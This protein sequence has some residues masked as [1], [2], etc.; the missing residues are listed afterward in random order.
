MNLQDFDAL[1]RIF[2]DKDPLLESLSGNSFVAAEKEDDR[3]DKGS[4][5]NKESDRRFRANE[6]LAN[7]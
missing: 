1:V 7:A 6:T 5:R 3:P 2:Q 4:A